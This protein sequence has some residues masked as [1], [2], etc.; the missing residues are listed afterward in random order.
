V[1]R[2]PGVLTGASFAS[3]FFLGVASAVIGA[4]SGNIGWSPSQTGL[5]ISVQNLGFILSVVVAGSLADTR[6]KPRLLAAGSVILAASFF[7]FYLWRP[8]TLNLAIMFVIGIG[9]GVYEGVADAMLL[10][11]HRE[12]KGMFISINH[13][14]VTFGCLAITVYL[15]FLPMEGWRRSL[16]QSAVVVLVLALVFALSRTGERGGEKSQGLRARAAYLRTQGVLAVFLAAAVMGVGIELGL[17]GLLP[18]FLSEIRGYDPLAARVGLALFLGGVAVGRVGLGVLS[19]SGRILPFVLG[20]FASA[21]VLC[22]VLFFVP[23]PR[24]WTAVVL[25]LTG[26]TVS[27][28]IPLTITMT[29]LRYPS[30]SGTALGIVKLGIP[31]GGIVV[32]FLVSMISGWASFHVSLALFPA[33][34]AGGFLLLALSRKMIRAG[35]Q[36]GMA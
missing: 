22:S 2:N 34:G 10:G 18:G 7:L 8:Y 21:A 26:I 35:T 32:P 24:A 13:F 31:L 5:L 9:I 28:L 6:E 20:L 12:R 11:I 25:V 30:M 14:F 33:L 15:V 29:G 19:R 23:L 17:T 27:A 1:I 16:V 36:T 3:M 4:A